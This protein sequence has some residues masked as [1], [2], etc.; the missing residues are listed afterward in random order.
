MSTTRLLSLQ[1]RIHDYLLGA[2]D[3]SVLHDAIVDD[4]R[5]GAEKRLRIYHDSYRLRLIEALSKTHPNLFKLLGDDLF[6]QTARAYIAGH[7]SGNRNLR[8]Y[9]GELAEHLAVALARHPIASEL[10]RFEWALALAFDCAD[11][12]VLTHVELSSVQ[13]EDWG[14]LRF[15]LHPSVRRLD[16][17]LNTVA[18]WQSLDQDREPPAIEESPSSW[19]IWRKGL[20]PHYRSLLENERMCLALIANGASFADVCEA[21]SIADIEADT[22]LQAAGYLSTWLADGLLSVMGCTTP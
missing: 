13:P 4:T 9:G 18:V 12:P 11:A 10:A 7:P 16:L 21:L 6:E 8:W 19:L 14:R 17:K 22:T 20:D 2:G 3:A 5:V 15:N 1:E